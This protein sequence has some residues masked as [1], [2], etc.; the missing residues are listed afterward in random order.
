MTQKEWLEKMAKYCAYQERCQFEVRSKL[1]GSGLTDDEI[2][3]IICEL[4]AQNFID[5]LRFARAF[6]R[7]KFNIKGWGKIKIK[8]HLKQK[9]ISDYC[10]NKGLSEIS[11]EDYYCKLTELLQKKNSLL[12]ADNEFVKKQKIARFLIGKGFESEMVWEELS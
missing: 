4:I 2:E 8:Q 10:I 5:E 9:K 6:S 3:N 1:F 7:G 12:N 11:S